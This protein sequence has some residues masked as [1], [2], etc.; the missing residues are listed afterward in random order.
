MNALIAIGAYCLHY[1]CALWCWDIAKTKHRDE[2]TWWFLGFFFGL[3]ALLVIALLGEPRVKK[4]PIDEPTVRE[5][6]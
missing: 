6:P 1:V 2:I 3:F 5:P 4:S